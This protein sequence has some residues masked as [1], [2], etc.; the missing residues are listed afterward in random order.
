MTV[1]WTIIII[2]YHIYIALFFIGI[3]PKVLYISY[4]AYIYM[5]HML[6]HHQHVK[7]NDEILLYQLCLIVS[8]EPSWDEILLY[9]LCLIVLGEPSWDRG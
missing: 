8:G 6:K 7:H 1:V 5:K 9:Q 2:I 3:H 4:S